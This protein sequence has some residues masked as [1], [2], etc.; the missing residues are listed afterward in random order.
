MAQKFFKFGLKCFQRRGG[1]RKNQRY[2]F[3]Y[4]KAAGIG[5]Y[6][7]LFSAVKEWKWG[8]VYGR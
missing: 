8:M 7:P 3:V 6:D 4:S 1:G 5:S 2:M